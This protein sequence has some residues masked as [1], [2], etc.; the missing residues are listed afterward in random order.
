MTESKEIKLITPQKV[1]EILGVKTSTLTI[2]RSRGTPKLDYVKIG[3]KVMYS[4][5]EINDF[6]KRQT[7][8]P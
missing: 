1:S 6:I 8:N 4:T 3:G 2:W 7:V 5:S